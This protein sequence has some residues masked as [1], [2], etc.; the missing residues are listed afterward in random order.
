MFTVDDF[1]VTGNDARIPDLVWQCAQ[2]YA[3]ALQLTLH[4][5]VPR[6]DRGLCHASR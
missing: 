5:R 6:Q 1:T 4:V 2:R 3:A